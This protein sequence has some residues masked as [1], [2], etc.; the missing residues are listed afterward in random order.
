MN[1]EK[2]TKKVWP[3]FEEKS[4]EGIPLYPV[5]YEPSKRAIWT[6]EFRP[7]K[8]GE[9]YLSGAIVEAYKAPNDL[10]T[11]RHIAKIANVRRKISFIIED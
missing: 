8:K 3:K 11:P 1:V 2:A 10:D 9:W 6:G 5:P 4:A 7:P